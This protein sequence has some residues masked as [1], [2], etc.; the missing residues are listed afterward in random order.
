MPVYQIGQ[1]AGYTWFTDWSNNA[2]CGWDSH[3]GENCRKVLIVT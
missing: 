3:L 1:L 2:Q